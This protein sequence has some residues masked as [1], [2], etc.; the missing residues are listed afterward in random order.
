[1]TN[2]L[3]HDS[4]NLVNRCVLFLF[5]INLRIVFRY[6]LDLNS[7]VEAIEIFREKQKYDCTNNLKI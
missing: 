6:T 3:L 4:L 1:M 5:D 7:F 2:G